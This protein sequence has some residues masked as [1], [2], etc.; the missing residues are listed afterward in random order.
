M[1]T[2]SLRELQRLFWHSIADD[3][4]EPVLAPGLV[5]VVEPSSTLDADARL[6]VYAEAYFWRLRDVLAEDFPQ[7][8]RLLG[9]DRFE[10]VVRDYLKR[11][12]SEDPSVRHLGRDMAA[13]FHRR[14]GLPRY[15]GDLARLEWAR[16]E[17]FDAPDTEPLT[18]GGLRRVAPED[19]P[20]LRFLPSPALAVIRAGWRVH[21]IW[22][23]A[24]PAAIAA[25][26]TVLRVWRAEDY[27]VFHAPM[28]ARATEALDRLIAGEPFAAICGA[29]AD[30]V[31][32]EAAREATALLARWI[33]DGIIARAE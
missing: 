9:P 11:H 32:H 12:P 2:P 1:P 29:F 14:A 15:L 31:P 22:A 17:V 7:A 8:A 25:A 21:E 5:E 19:W 33:E 18:A 16:L 6:R 23:G 10:D 3:P 20:Q 26:P 27:T 4:G 13:F 30:L 24:D 28:D